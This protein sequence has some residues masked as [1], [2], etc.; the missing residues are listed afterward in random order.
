MAMSYLHKSTIFVST[1]FVGFH[2][3]AEAPDEVG[4]LRDLHRHVFH[5]KVDVQ[6]RHNDRELEYHMVLKGLGFFIVELMDRWKSG[7]SCEDI[8]QKI[9]GWVMGT[10]PDRDHY[11][12]TVAEDGENGSTLEAW[13]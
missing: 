12:V 1:Q 2:Q 10:Y 11:R 9:M 8:A 13:G 6:V 5:V 7:W 3:W 4:Y